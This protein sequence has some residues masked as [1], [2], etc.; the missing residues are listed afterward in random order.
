M[1]LTIDGLNSTSNGG[2]TVTIGAGTCRDATDSVDIVIPT[3]ETRTVDVTVTGVG[4]VVGGVQPN[5]SYA[6]YVARND[7]SG[8]VVCALTTDFSA[9][10]SG[11]KVRRIG[12]VLT[13]QSS[14]VV[15]F[16]QTGTSNAR[17]TSYDV[18]P[19]ILTV[20]NGLS[21]ASFQ[22][23]EL[24]PPKPQTAPTSRLQVAPSGGKTWVSV[25]ASQQ[26]G[27]VIDV[28]STTTF[29]FTPPL[30]TGKGSF[31]TASGATT[32]IRVTG[33]SEDV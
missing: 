9:S 21:S 26:P 22:D 15:A 16:T 4:G 18:T 27:L 5:T 20:V 6:L 7:S 14:Q 19:P 10:V 30:D 32:S 3:G 24:G 28:T 25:D 1:S 31:K 13:N 8:A 23:F 11:Y 17:Q 2:N 33:F 12:A 29:G